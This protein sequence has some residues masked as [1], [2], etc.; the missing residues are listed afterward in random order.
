[1]RG[2]WLSLFF[3]VEVHEVIQ[4]I[5]VAAGSDTITLEGDELNPVAQC[6]RGRVSGDGNS[7]CSRRSGA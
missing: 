3:D 5:R 1:M 6:L 4:A 7:S 2:G